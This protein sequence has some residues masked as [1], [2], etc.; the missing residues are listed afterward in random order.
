M[1]TVEEESTFRKANCDGRWVMDFDG[2]RSTRPHIGLTSRERGGSCHQAQISNSGPGRLPA[3]PTGGR[4]SRER[5]P[6]VRLRSARR[7][8]IGICPSVRFLP[9]WIFAPTEQA[10]HPSHLILFLGSLRQEQN[11]RAPLSI[12]ATAQKP[13]GGRLR[14]LVNLTSPAVWPGLSSRN[15]GGHA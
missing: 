5:S 13:S 12:S 3:Q 2:L 11:F 9:D 14:R 10:A 15:A 8:T 1:S 4:W 7:L 6:R